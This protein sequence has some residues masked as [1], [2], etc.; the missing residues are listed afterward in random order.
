[1]RYSLFLVGCFYNNKYFL[2]IGYLCGVIM[3]KMQTIIKIEITTTIK[4][5]ILCL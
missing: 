5:N 3:S 4:K 2:P 1:M